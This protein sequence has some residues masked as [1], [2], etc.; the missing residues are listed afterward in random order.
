MDLIL[1]IVV[2]FVLWLVYALYN[3][4]NGIIAEMREM[5]MKC[6]GTTTE[7]ME[8]KLVE[9]PVEKELFKIPDTVVS[10]LKLLLKFA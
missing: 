7:K 9:K 3:A 10:G 4:Y 8:S 6:I 2:A 5:R 1:L